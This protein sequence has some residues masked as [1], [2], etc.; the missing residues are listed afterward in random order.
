[1]AGTG[2]PAPGWAR[3]RPD[4]TFGKRMTPLGEQHHIW[5]AVTTSPAPIDWLTWAE[6]HLQSI[7]LVAKLPG[8]PQIAAPTTSELQP[9]VPSGWSARGS[10]S[11]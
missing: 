4:L 11:L 7:D 5:S 9:F 2:H 8:P 1:M 6:V 3:W 10:G